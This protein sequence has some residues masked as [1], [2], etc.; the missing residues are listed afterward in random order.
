MPLL[1]AL[2]VAQLSVFLATTCPNCGCYILERIAKTPAFMAPFWIPRE[3]ICCNHDLT[4]FPEATGTMAVDSRKDRDLTWADVS[5]SADASRMRIEQLE[6]ENRELKSEI[7]RLE[8]VVTNSGM[9]V[10]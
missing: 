9:P 2:Y 5:A 3:C 6:G 1:A 4:D 10:I 7:K 8:E